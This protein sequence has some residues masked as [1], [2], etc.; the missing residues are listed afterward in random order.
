MIINSVIGYV[1]LR[2]D[3]DKYCGLIDNKKPR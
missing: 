1:L 3:L 2:S